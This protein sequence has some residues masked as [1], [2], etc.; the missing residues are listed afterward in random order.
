LIIAAGA[1]NW[2]AEGNYNAGLAKQNNKN[3][4]DSR[5]A[6][7]RN[8]N[9]PQAGSGVSPLVNS[10]TRSIIGIYPYFYGVSSTQPTAANI[11]SAIAAGTTNKVLIDAG[12]PITITFNAVNQF[13]WFAAAAS[14]ADKTTWYNT[15][16]N[17]GSIGGGQFILSPVQQN[18]N[19][20]NSYWSAISF[21]IYISGFATTT[22]GSIIFS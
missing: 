6:L 13:V 19:S 17:N 16:L 20:P 11:A 12:S 15:A 4:T 5:T 14:Y 21:D 2:T 10:T 22:S 18:V 1:T 3:V 7:I 8:V 9:A